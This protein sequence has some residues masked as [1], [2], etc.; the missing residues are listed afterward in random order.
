LAK[1]CALAKQSEKEGILVL[2]LLLESVHQHLLNDKMKKRLT[3]A[4][5]IALGSKLNL[6]IRECQP[7]QAQQLQTPRRRE[8]QEAEILQQEAIKSIK[9][10]PAVNLLLSSFSA[11]LRE[12]TIKTLD[13]EHILH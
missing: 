1:H 2:E 10:D 8:I 13:R 5:Q 4:L 11:S 12:E 6:K 7:K 9:T 3:D